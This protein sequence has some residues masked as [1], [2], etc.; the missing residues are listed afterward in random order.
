MRSNTTGKSIATVDDGPELPAMFARYKSRVEQELSRWVPD[1][2]GADPY[3]LLRYH[4]GWVDQYGT[5]AAVPISQGKALRPTLCMFACEALE[6]DPARA[7]PAAAALELIHNFSLIHDDIQD[8][9]AERRHQPT[10]WSLWGVPKALVA[11]NAMQSIGDVA[12][13]DTSRYEAPPETVLKVSQIL[14]DSYLEMI[15]GQ[16]LDLA[17][18]SNTTIG[19][20][21][22]L[23]MISYKTGALIR[24]SLEIGALLA[25]DDPTTFESFSRFGS[26]LGKAFQIR[27]DVLGIWGESYL[28]GK[29]AGNDIRRRKK[30]FPVVFAFEQASGQALEDLQRIYGKEEVDDEDVERVLAVLD[31]VGAQD[32]SET[33][34]EDT[35]GDALEALKLIQLPNWAKDEAEALVDFLARR[36]Y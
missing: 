21:D 12:L 34:T 31:E 3:L 2:E 16:C 8:R 27:D 11:G 5:P 23:R 9:D 29:P 6:E 30:S 4:L 20:E 15:Q 14:T 18:E 25:T 7:M 26:Y 17:F 28:T 35:A 19:T 1:P 36:Q 32:Q 10:V 22:Y 33:L 13:L 24:S